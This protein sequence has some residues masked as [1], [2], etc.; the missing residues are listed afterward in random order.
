MQISD[1]RYQI[2][3][4][5]PH[6]D[7]WLLVLFGLHLGHAL[8]FATLYPYHVQDTDLLAYFIYFQNLQNLFDPQMLG[9][10]G[11]FF[12]PKPLLCFL[13]GPLGNAQWAFYVTA[14]M[15][16]ALG[17]VVYLVGRHF[18]SRGLGILLSLFLLLDPFKGILTLE[19]SA[20]L[21]VTLFLFLALYGFAVHRPSVSAVCLLLSALVKPVA[22][23]C[24]AIFFLRPD[25]RD[26]VDTPDPA[27][28]AD[29]NDNN[30]T[31]M[32][33]WAL[34]PGLAIPLILFSN[35]LLLG[36]IFGSAKLLAEFTA[37][38]QTAPLP[39]QDFLHFIFWEHFIQ[40][41]FGFSAVF[42][43]VGL[44]LWLSKE[45]QRLLSPF[46]LLPLLFLG[47]YVLIGFISPHTP[48]LRF[49]WPLEI[50]FLA[51]I[52]YGLLEG[53]QRIFSSKTILR[54]CVIALLL[55]FPLGDA[56]RHHMT[57]R[58]LFVLPFEN[59]MAFVT[60]AVQ[61]LKHEKQPHETILSPVAFMPYVMW[62]LHIP[63]WAGPI[64]PA[65]EIS[66][67]KPGTH[68]D[69]IVYVPKISANPQ[70]IR[71]V[72]H[73]IDQGAYELR[74]SS[75]TAALLHR[76]S[77]TAGEENEMAFTSTQ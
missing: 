34:I 73:L 44:L 36:S 12:V 43:L 23:P 58:N 32:W 65:E 31:P 46:F 50:W 56:F 57:Y 9:P 7:I 61:V 62:E 10:S 30:K 8:L 76:T 51:F 4:R 18:F 59:E 16:A 63:E 24:A 53:T 75:Q 14:V 37:L 71:H 2:L 49:Y 11:R 52:L 17:S 3:H 39:A 25:K 72:K 19:S 1:I 42:A 26:A 35:W 68:P 74:L 20:D 5:M 6:R 15:S 67:Q 45:K 22:L 66:L 13:L 69:W 70:S 77:H 38:R 40:Y 64:I 28:P 33:R 29:P 27:D 48:F 54:P 55:L 47:G 21:Y 60:S 41:R